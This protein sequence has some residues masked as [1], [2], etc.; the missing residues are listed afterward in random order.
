MAT[1]EGV[2]GFSDQLIGRLDAKTAVI[3]VIGMGYVG[4]PLALAFCRAGQKVIGFDVDETK[5]AA[6][7][8][9]QSYIRHFTDEQIGQAL[10]SGRFQATVA[11]E[12]L[13]EADALIICVP[14]PL[15][16]QR[17]PD[18][19]F[20]ESTARTIAS[21][22]RQGQ[23][24]SF[25]ST[26]YPGS[27][28]ELLV[29]ILETSGLRCD[30]DF[31]FVYSPERE[32]PANPDFETATIPKVLGAGS[33][34]ARAAGTR[35]YREVT[36]RV[37]PV[38]NAKTAEAVKLTENIFRAVNIA[39]VNELKLIYQQ[40]G[41]DVWEVIEA[42]KT[43]PFGFMAFYPGPGLGGHC[44]PI[45]PFYL[46]WKAREFDM[47][48]RF[49]ELA[50]EVN[51][52]MPGHVVR[53]IS[54][55]LNDHQGKA[56]KDARV[57]VVGLAYKKNVD[58]MRESPS[59]E[60]IERLEGLGAIVGYHDRF[61]PVIPPSREHGTLAG[62]AAV[63]W[64]REVLSSF[65]CAVICTDHDGV[66]YALLSESV[67]TVVDTRNIEAFGEAASAKVVKA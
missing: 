18:M 30:D 34:A 62:R 7:N 35:L 43:K 26:T 66:D 45:D 40:M 12:R 46:S 13:G 59:L 51:K 6:L 41:I 32:D 2:T 25:E 24:V 15:T 44:I 52:A 3:G 49:I 21:Y 60:I 53:A 31:L 50:G 1:H 23:L 56:L 5:V 27:C 57:L 11:M 33:E 48:A 58:D 14:T 39:L 63:E 42:A 20:V 10:A 61:I 36:E 22:L 65:D 37:V 55:A 47:N 8:G 9:G 38:S 19:S 4:L 54:D 67:R 17:D 16:R 28:D 64:T 29:P